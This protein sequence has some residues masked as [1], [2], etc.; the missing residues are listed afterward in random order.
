[1]GCYIWY[2]EEGPGRDR[3]PPRP[4]LECTAVEASDGDGCVVDVDEGNHSRESQQV[5]RH[6]CLELRG[7]DHHGAL[8]ARQFTGI[9]SI[10]CSARSAKIKKADITIAAHCHDVNVLLSNISL[11]DFCCFSSVVAASR[12][13]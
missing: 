2:S 5:L 7:N 4:L 13:I 11:F 1:M 12:D 10:V 6:V 8:F 3:S 9:A